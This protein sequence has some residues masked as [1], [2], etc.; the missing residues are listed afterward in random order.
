MGQTVNHI[1]CNVIILGDAVRNYLPV[2]LSKGVV[3]EES[4]ILQL[5]KI[6]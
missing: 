1:Q 5:L 3:N 6:V 2:G 4:N